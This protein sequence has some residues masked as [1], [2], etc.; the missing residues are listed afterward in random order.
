M[1]TVEDDD[2][3]VKKLNELRRS[4]ADL[5]NR[6]SFNEQ[7]L[8]SVEQKVQQTNIPT[9]AALVPFG[10]RPVDI[11]LDNMVPLRV[12]DKTFPT[13][14]LSL[15]KTILTLK[16]AW[17]A[18]K[19]VVSPSISLR[20]S[21]S[22]L[23]EARAE[24]ELLNTMRV[25]RAIQKCTK[26]LSKAIRNNQESCVCYIGPYTTDTLVIAAGTKQ[27]LEKLKYLV[28]ISITFDG[29]FL[30]VDIYY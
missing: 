5:F 13:F 18:L 28:D 2:L 1:M 3:N 23:Q 24:R 7:R 21:A 12:T 15:F 25:Q 6:I 27:H 19:D 14:S 9:T 8:E 17:R 16:N 30:L 26:A 29:V 11:Q 20:S 4:F 10:S 22:V